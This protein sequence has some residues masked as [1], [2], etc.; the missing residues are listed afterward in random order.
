LRRSDVRERFAGLG[1]G[2][3]AGSANYL[4]RYLQT[5]V[6]KWASVTRAAGIKVE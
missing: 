4:A 1:I 3:V 5:E 6:T 2:I